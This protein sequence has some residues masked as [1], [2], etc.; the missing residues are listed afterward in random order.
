MLDG[1]TEMVPIPQAIRNMRAILPPPVISALTSGRSASRTRP[2]RWIILGVALAL[3]PYAQAQ[4]RDTLSV[5]FLSDSQDP[6]W[7]ESLVLK[8]YHN[9]QARD[10]ILG[11]ILSREPHAVV[12]LG[13]MVSAGANTKKWG[14]IDE[15]VDSL[16]AKGIGFHPILG[17]H[18]YYYFGKKGRRNFERRFP[19]LNTTGR[20][21]RFGGAAIVL[22]NSN[23]SRL[24]KSEQHYQA[25]W[26]RESLRALDADSTIEFIIVGCHHPPYTNSTIVPPSPEVDTAFVPAFLETRKAVLFVSGHAHAYEHYRRAGKDFL[27]IGGG[28]GLLQPLLTGTRQRSEDLFVAEGKTR[29]YHYLW[30]ELEPGRLRFAVRMIRRDLSGFDGVDSLEFVLPNHSATVGGKKNT[31]SP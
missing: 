16:E 15:F 18:E 22:L 8:V 30:C 6:T 23:F 20:I 21:V 7:Y 11:D 31:P 14:R 29:M 17:N 10:M 25:K 28:G 9:S 5:A 24:E 19:G 27:V 3:A 2:V 4:P 1:Y 12:H 26:Y 13:D